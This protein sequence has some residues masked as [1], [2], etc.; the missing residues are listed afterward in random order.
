[1]ICQQELPTW[2]VVIRYRVGPRRGECWFMMSKDDDPIRIAARFKTRR[3]AKRAADWFNQSRKLLMP[4]I[5]A[6][7]RRALLRISTA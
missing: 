2:V 7:P 1:V 5:Y 6:T 3:E 4:S